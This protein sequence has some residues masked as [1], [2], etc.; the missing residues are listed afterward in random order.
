MPP[1]ALAEALI[2]MKCLGEKKQESAFWNYGMTGL[3]SRE[4]TYPTKRE[5]ENHRL[6]MPF[7]GGYV[8]FQE[9]TLPET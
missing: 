8:N 2:A 6:K 9:G 1:Q 3:P 4:F 5:K 7:L